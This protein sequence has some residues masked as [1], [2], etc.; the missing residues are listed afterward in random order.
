MLTV[1]PTNPQHLAPTIAMRE[2]PETED[3]VA[4][5]IVKVQKADHKNLSETPNNFGAQELR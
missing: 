3:L 1:S 2:L 5:K 4:A